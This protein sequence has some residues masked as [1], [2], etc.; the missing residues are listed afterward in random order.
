MAGVTALRDAQRDLLA[1]GAGAGSTGR[2][3]DEEPPADWSEPATL[4]A[5][6]PAIQRLRTTASYH[7]L[8]RKLFSRWSQRRVSPVQPQPGVPHPRA[9][10]RAVQSPHRSVSRPG[11]ADPRVALAARPPPDQLGHLEA[12]YYAAYHNR[13]SDAGPADASP[14]TRMSWTGPGGGGRLLALCQLPTRVACVVARARLGSASLRLWPYARPWDRVAPLTAAE[15]DAV[16]RAC[17]R[18]AG[19]PLMLCHGFCGAALHWTAACVRAAGSASV[20]SRG[21]R[22][23]QAAPGVGPMPPRWF[24]SRACNDFYDTAVAED[25]ARSLDDPAPRAGCRMCDAAAN[26]S[27]DPARPRAGSGGGGGGGATPTNPLPASGAAGVG[28]AATEDLWHLLFDCPHPVM[29]EQREEMRASAISHYTAMCE[30]IAEASNRAERWYPGDSIALA[31]T[32]VAVEDACR[33]V[34]ATR[35]AGAALEP[36]VVYRLILALPFPQHAVPDRPQQAA[37]PFAASRALGRVYDSVRLTNTLLRSTATR[38]V[39][40]ASE[41]IRAIA[42]ARRAV[43]FPPPPRAPPPCRPPGCVPRAAASRSH[44]DAV[45]GGTAD[46]PGD[47]A[48]PPDEP[49]S[50]YGP[51]L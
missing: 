47:G 22:R 8:G 48:G 18:E 27:S 36:F 3:K 29:R 46:P 9:V 13:P 38:A 7:L 26:A 15:R 6:L 44:D 42:D 28:A 23:R 4:R 1:I 40:W 49:Q 41:R 25:A 12:I 32:R 16:C 31:D 20:F 5:V 45:A 11:D 34:E 14:V 35:D 30:S 33:V 43:L 19:G 10:R 2:N 17:G 39:S 50:P 37:D 24:C 21:G 51:Y